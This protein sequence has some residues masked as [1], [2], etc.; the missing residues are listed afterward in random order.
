MLVICV[1]RSVELAI[2]IR[3]N[4]IDIWHFKIRRKGCQDD[5]PVFYLKELQLIETIEDD[6]F[7]VMT[8]WRHSASGLHSS[9][10]IPIHTEFPWYED[11]GQ[12]Q[13]SIAWQ[14]NLKSKKR[15]K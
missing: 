1:V 5:R 2:I 6:Y 11:D 13:T 12:C 15:C 7:P 14:H 9:R 8:A 3:P 10:P 4:Q